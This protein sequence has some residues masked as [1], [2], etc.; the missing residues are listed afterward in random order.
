METDQAATEFLELFREVYLRLHTRWDKHERRPSAEALAVMTHLQA[1]G[2]LTVAEASNHFDRAQSA[3]SELFDRLEANEFVVRYKDSRDKR[4]TFIWLTDT[5]IEVLA[6]ANRPLD[7]E[8]IHRTIEAM[9]KEDQS[10]LLQGLSA[11]IESARQLKRT[12]GETK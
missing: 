12:E 6:K 11:F 9:P 1:C 2:P 4:R 7:L 3:M 8:R 5:G 10:K